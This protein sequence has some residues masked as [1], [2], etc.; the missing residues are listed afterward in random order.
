M[1]QVLHL[2][3]SHNTHHIQQHKSQMM[4]QVL[5][6]FGTWTIYIE[7][8]RRAPEITVDIL[9]M[10]SNYKFVTVTFFVLTFLFTW[11]SLLVFLLVF[12][13]VYLKCFAAISFIVRFCHSLFL[14]GFCGY[15]CFDLSIRASRSVSF[16]MELS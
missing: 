13:A 7:G 2:F 16:G 11:F 3:N 12:V 5:Q 10:F 1:K 15:S 6:E 14:K 8:H 4:Q 9:K